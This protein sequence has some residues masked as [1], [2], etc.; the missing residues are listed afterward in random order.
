MKILLWCLLPIMASISVIIWC[1]G[2]I[3][4][5]AVRVYKWTYEY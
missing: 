3:I 1:L 2:Y 4:G 5:L